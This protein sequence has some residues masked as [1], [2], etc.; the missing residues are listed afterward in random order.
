[1][2]MR[3]ILIVLNWAIPFLLLGMVD[4]DESPMWV[5]DG[6]LLWF[7]SASFLMNYANRRGWLD[8]LNKYLKGFETD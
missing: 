4:M 8:R 3:A 7:A 1:M 6:A 2:N 5:L